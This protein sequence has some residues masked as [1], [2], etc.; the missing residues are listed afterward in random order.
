MD[1]N[2]FQ[3]SLDKA[4]QYV[5]FN[6]VSESEFDQYLLVKLQDL[7][8][9]RT[10]PERDPEGGNEDNEADG[11]ESLNMLGKEE[12]QEELDLFYF[13]RAIDLNDQGVLA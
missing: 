12:I 6:L 11:L 9:N 3:N 13:N 10:P 1:V 7:K 5:S 4:K 8:L 2:K